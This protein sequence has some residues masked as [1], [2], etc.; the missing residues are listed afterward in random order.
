MIGVLAPV[1]NE[2]VD[3]DRIDHC[4][5]QYVRANF[6]TLFEDDDGEIGIELFQPDRG[7]QSRR[8]GAHDNNVEFH[9]LTF[10]LVHPCLHGRS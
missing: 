3:T 2:L 9:A 4:A 8:P 7:S 6:A 1:G 10:N 5:R